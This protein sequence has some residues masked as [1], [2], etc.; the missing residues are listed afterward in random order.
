MR[1]RPALTALTILLMAAAC[2]GGDGVVDGPAQT[3]IDGE[4]PYGV[5]VEV[6]E[7]Y[8]YT[9][10]TH[11]GI[12]WTP[13]DGVWWQASAPLNDGSGNP[14]SGW[15]NPYDKGEMDIVDAARAIY[16]GGPSDV[17]FERT[18]VVD[19]PFACE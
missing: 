15:G 8:D 18:E 17:E 9:L 14:P 6:G 11:C 4:A 7:T 2:G 3:D 16:R 12:E 13:I 10:Y 1:R 19:A 5:G